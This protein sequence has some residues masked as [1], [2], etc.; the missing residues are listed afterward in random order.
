SAVFDQFAGE[1]A[2]RNE[3]RFFAVRQ[4]AQAPGGQIDLD[5][6]AGLR[7]IHSLRAFDRQEAVVDRVTE[8]DSRIALGDD[9]LDSR[10]AQR[11]D[12]VLARRSAAEIVA[13][14]HYVARPDPFDEGRVDVFH[15][16]LGQFGLFVNVQVA[17]RNDLVSV[18]VRA[19]VYVREA[20]QVG[21]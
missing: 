17:R 15:R 16:V 19:F 9:D 6:I 21:W 3:A 13:R 8:E 14:D 1:I 4:I 5:L 7:D 2:Q 12:P 11:P 10:A 18:D 20:F